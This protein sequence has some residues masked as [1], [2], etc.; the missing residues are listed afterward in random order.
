[1]PRYVIPP[2]GDTLVDEK[3][4]DE[5]EEEEVVTPGEASN[6]VVCFGDSI[7]LYCQDTAGYVYSENTR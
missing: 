6:Q 4:E 1:M 7:A 2:T 3:E 5:E